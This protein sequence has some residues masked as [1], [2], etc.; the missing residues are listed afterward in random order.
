MPSDFSYVD[1]GDVYVT[2]YWGRITLVD[3]LET[4]MK[5]AHDSDMKAARAH[6]VDLS[7]AVWAE[8]DPHE[9]HQQ[10]ERLRPAFAPPKVRSLFVA[11]GD[12]FYGFAIMYALM[13]VVYGA[14]KVEVFRDWAGAAGA[15]GTPLASAES[16]ARSR[17]A[18][19]A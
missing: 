9:V 19:G 3:I 10:L 18:A 12:F 13:H 16:W 14:A 7:H 15:L 2:V 6:V 1:D 17:A 5:R 8:T 4:I 11:A